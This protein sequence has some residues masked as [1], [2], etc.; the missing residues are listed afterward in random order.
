MENNEERDKSKRN[1]VL[2][3]ILG[4]ATLLVA[5]VGATFAYFTASITGNPDQNNINISTD[6]Y[7]LT[8]FYENSKDRI[9]IAN[10]NLSKGT[11]SDSDPTNYPQGEIRFRVESDSN[12]IAK[13]NIGFTGLTNDFCQKIDPANRKECNEL[14]GT[15]NVSGEAYYELYECDSNYSNCGAT[16]ASSGMPTSSGPIKEGIDIDPKVDGVKGV[17]YFVLKAFIANKEH[18]QDYNQGK[19]FSAKVVVSEYVQP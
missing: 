2:L 13:I 16:L 6:S 11:A 9:D 7:G 5:L 14:T 19:T 3:T 17:G 8:V 4:I 15:E 18:A 1:T 12:A 10:A